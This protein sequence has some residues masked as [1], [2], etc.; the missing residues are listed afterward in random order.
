MRYGRIIRAKGN[1][2]VCSKVHDRLPYKAIARQGPLRVGGSGRAP[3]GL[4]MESIT[5]THA[6][7]I[8]RAR[9]VRPIKPP[10]ASKEC[11]NLAK[12]VSWSWREISLSS[13]GNARP[14]YS[15]KW[16]QGIVRQYGT[17]AAGE[18]SPAPSLRV[19]SELVRELDCPLRFMPKAGKESKW[20]PFRAMFVA[21]RFS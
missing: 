11:L 10:G 16:I 17:G 8:R 1:N 12:E 2:Y 4:R 3:A 19:C 21:K 13:P 9:N 15:T 7:E 18:Y 5:R 20:K 6:A 14:G